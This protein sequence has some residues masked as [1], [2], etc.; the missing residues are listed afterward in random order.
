MRSELKQIKNNI[1]IYYIQSVFCIRFCSILSS[2]HISPTKKKLQSIN[3]GLV[4]VGQP[5]NQNI[6]LIIIE[7]WERL[8]VYE[9]YFGRIE[10]SLTAPLRPFVVRV[11]M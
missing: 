3:I 7:F 2:T 5:F 6:T 1:Q 10:K 4:L 8:L 11:V 9:T